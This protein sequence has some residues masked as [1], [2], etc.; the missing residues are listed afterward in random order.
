MPNPVATDDDPPGDT[1]ETASISATS[2]HR[3]DSHTALFVKGP[4]RRLMADRVGAPWDLHVCQKP[5][6]L[7][8]G[9]LAGNKSNLSSLPSSNRT[10]HRHY[11]RLVR[12]PRTLTRPQ[13]PPALRIVGK[14]AGPSA[15]R[16]ADLMRLC[17]IRPSWPL[18]AQQRAA[19]RVLAHGWPRSGADRVPA[20]PRQRHGRRAPQPVGRR[21]AHR[22]PERVDRAGSL[23]GLPA[24]RGCGLELAPIGERQSAGRSPKVPHHRRFVRATSP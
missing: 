14:H 23:R 21:W 19:A 11:R 6:I 16:H 22:L 24:G 9:S 18:H 10:P 15:L 8:H 2:W 13:R 7:R 12:L 1:D 3:T 4:G 17:G 20:V 5:S